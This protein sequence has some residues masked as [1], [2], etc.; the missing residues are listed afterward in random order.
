ME[1]LFKIEN[2][3]LIECLDKNVKEV[4]IPNTVTS[5]GEYAFIN[6]ESLTNITIPDSVTSIGVEAFAGCTSL[7]S[8]T[9]PNSLT[10]IEEGAF[11]DCIS[12]TEIIIPN[13]VTYIGKFAFWNCMSLKIYCEASSKPKKGWNTQWSGSRK[14]VWGYKVSDS[15]KENTEIVTGIFKIKAGKLIK[16]LD[17]NTKEVVIPDGVTSIGVNAFKG[18]KA[19]TSVEIPD[20]VNSIDNMAFLDCFSLESITIPSSV[21]SIGRYAFYGSKLTK[22]NISS[23]DE[24]FNYS[25]GL[26]VIPR[27]F[28]EPYEYGYDLYLNDELVTNITIPNNIKEIKKYAFCCCKSLKS[29][30]LPN[31]VTKIGEGAFA[32]CESLTNI[33]LPNSITSIGDVAFF[34]CKSLTDV[35]IPDSVENIGFCAFSYCESLKNVTIPK[36]VTDIEGLSFSNCQSLVSIKVDKNNEVYDSRNNCNAIIETKTNKLIFGFQN[37]KIP[38]T[39]TIIG[40]GA[41]VGCSLLTNIVIPKNITKIEGFAFQQCS[42]LTSLT[43]SESVTYIGLNALSLCDKLKTITFLGSKE[44]WF[45]ISRNAGL[46]GNIIV[47]FSDIKKE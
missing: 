28:I 24:W 23:M 1:E 30:T 10:T 31:S 13:S 38:N 42:N 40:D 45:N 47:I 14:V 8:V 37:T 22:I 26:A 2:G 9:I 17:E 18:F 27:D 5:I 7:E 6:C 11:S 36:S 41:F 12:L 43:I 19:L 25:F 3:L 44:Q 20:S 39:V 32:G 46:S 33:T 35:L 21:K 29:V 16:C 34:S 15:T 4:V